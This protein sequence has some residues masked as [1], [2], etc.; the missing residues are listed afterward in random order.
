[1]G[2]MTLD[3]FYLNTSHC[4]SLVIIIA[5]SFIS[6]A[7]AINCTDAHVRVI[8]LFEVFCRSIVKKIA[9]TFTFSSS[10]RLAL[11]GQM[12]VRLLWRMKRLVFKSCVVNAVT[13]G[14]KQ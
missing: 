14:C 4:L 7:C 10:C 5:V 2:L 13:K 11:K 9:H 6:M 12:L 8:G 3:S 1:M